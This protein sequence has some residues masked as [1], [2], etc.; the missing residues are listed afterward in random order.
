MLLYLS[1]LSRFTL[2]DRAE[3]PFLTRAAVE[4]MPAVIPT[5]DFQ[6]F[7]GN[8]EWELELMNSKGMMLEP[9]PGTPACLPV[10]LPGPRCPCRC[11][12]VI[13]GSIGC[14]CDSEQSS[15]DRVNAF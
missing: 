3:I 15:E 8:G 1:G 2:V 14:G 9:V 6:W 5:E 12:A 10:Y 11:G 7:C 13:A 4:L